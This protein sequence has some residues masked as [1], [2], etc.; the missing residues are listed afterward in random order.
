MKFFA[1]LQGHA[2]YPDDLCAPV[3]DVEG[4]PQKRKRRRTKA[5]PRGKP[6]HGAPDSAAMEV[7]PPAG[8]AASAQQALSPPEAA[9]DGE[10]ACHHVFAACSE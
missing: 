5:A 2:F 4:K 9:S 8:G 3:P 1:W 10:A 6:Q 7:D